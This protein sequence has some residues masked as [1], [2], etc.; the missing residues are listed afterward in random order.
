EQRNLTVGKYLISP[1]TR[2]LDNGWFACSVSIRSGSGMATT[3]RVVRLTRLFRDQVAA[4]E[5]AIAEGL[6]WIGGPQRHAPAA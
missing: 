5:Y 3:D 1:L 6:Q 2:P 4:V